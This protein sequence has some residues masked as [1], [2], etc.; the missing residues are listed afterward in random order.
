ME[1]KIGIQD[2]KLGFYLQGLKANLDRLEKLVLKTFDHEFLKACQNG[3]RSRFLPEK[4][5]S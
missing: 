4:Y 2:T 5:G 1:Y 3:H